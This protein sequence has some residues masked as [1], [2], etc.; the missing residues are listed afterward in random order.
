[1][2]KHAFLIMAHKNDYVLQTLLHINAKVSEN[3]S[4]IKDGYLFYEGTKLVQ[5]NR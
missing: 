2:G 5:Y 3:R 4:N 1:M